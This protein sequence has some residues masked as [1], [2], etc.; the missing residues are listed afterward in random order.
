M[1]GGG[2]RIVLTIVWPLLGVS[3]R[4]RSP[5]MVSMR[6]PHQPSTS[7]GRPLRYQRTTG[8][9]PTQMQE[10]VCRIN[11]ALTEPWNKKTGRPKSCELYRAVEIACRW[12]RSSMVASRA[13]R[14]GS[15]RAA[16]RYWQPRLWRPR[17][18]PHRT[19]ARATPRCPCRLGR[20]VGGRLPQ[21]LYTASPVDSLMAALPSFSG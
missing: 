1:G 15:V 5:S 13:P 7:K 2:R 9:S 10:L 8:L 17:P 4:Q 21:R 12:P 6:L 3:L 18:P 14:K 20:G 16:R 19:S 11:G